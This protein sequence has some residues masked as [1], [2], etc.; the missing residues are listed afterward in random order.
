MLL[1]LCFFA[2]NRALCGVGESAVITLVFPWGAAENGMGEVGT[3]LADRENVGFYN[4]AGLG[5][6]NKRWH[7]GEIGQFYEPLLPAFNLPDL[8]HTSIAGCWQ[9]QSQMFGGFSVWMNFLNFGINEWTDYYGRTLGAARAW[10]MVT[11]VSWGFSL[12]EFSLPNHNLG[13]TTK[14]IWSELA[15]GYGPNGEGTAQGF[16]IDAGYLYTAPFGLRLGLNVAN[17]GPS[18][19]YIS[20]Q[21]SDPIPFTI[22]LALGF[23]RE[24][25]E[26]GLSIMRIRTEYRLEREFVKSYVDKNPEPFWKAI[27]R[28]I[29][30]DSFEDNMR[31][32]I[33]HIGA[34]MTVFNIG[35]LRWG[36]MHD[37]AGRRREMHIGLGV[38]AYNHI[39]FDWYYILSKRR[40]PARHGQWGISVRLHRLADWSS[41]D[42]RWWMAD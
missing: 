2:H 17:M 20:E 5:A 23:K 22:N 9:P 4:P 30:D 16:A 29:A 19:F 34:E 36:Y 3:A 21:D 40:S 37:E 28:D 18:V 11:G 38:T 41:K 8:W 35:S 39:D 6:N 25:I 1:L 7:S 10:E 13:I 27:S 33:H 24:I 12:A 26:Q 14:L 15:R 32:I 31:E 42:A